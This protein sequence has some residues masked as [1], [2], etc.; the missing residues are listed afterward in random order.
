MYSGRHEHPRH[1]QSQFAVIQD[2]TGKIQFYIKQ[3]DICLVKTRAFT[4]MC[5]K[6]WWAHRRH[7][8]CERFCIHN[9]TGE[10][11]IHIK[12]F[13]I[14]YQIA[15]AITCG[16]KKKTEKL[17][18]LPIRNSVT[19]NVTPTWSWTRCK[20]K[21]SWS[22]QRW[23]MRS[24]N[25]LN[26]RVCSWSWYTRT[27][28]HSRWWQQRPFITHHNALDVPM[29]MR[30]ANELYL[31]RLIVGGFDWVWR[32]QPK[33]PQWKEWTVHNPEFTVL[34]FYVA[35]FKDYEWMMDTTR[36]VAWKNSHRCERHFH[37][38]HWR[39]RDQFQSLIKGITC[40]MPLRNIPASTSVAWM[41]MAFVK[42]VKT[43]YSCWCEMGQGKLID[44]IFG[45][46]CES[47]YVQP[48][49]ITDYPVEMSPL[50]KKHRSK[51]GP[52]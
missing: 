1:G 35:W 24:V 27:A 13:S 10:T 47:H 30:I 32:I 6:N 49:F 42:Y 20:R 29:Y 37:C 23:S 19:G 17:L 8:W 50:T 25:F 31:K 45:S 22:G 52:L 16:E 51:P 5:G 3:D 14:Y 11:S 21:L 7:C 4:S 26:E 40:T 39:Q 48:T 43:E 2:A 15:Q 18:M 36:T 46:K 34:E 41:K 38:Y 44:E 33:L 12:E 9:Q 28:E